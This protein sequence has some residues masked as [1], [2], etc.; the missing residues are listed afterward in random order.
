MAA[1]LAIFV[2]TVAWWA[3]ALWPT[4][5]ATPEW[6]ERTRAACFGSPPGGLPDTRGWLLLIGE[7]LGMVALL[8]VVW[9]GALSADIRRWHRSLAGR[10]VLYTL[11]VLVLGLLTLAVRQ[12]AA[13]QR[14]GSPPAVEPDGVLQQFSAN[15]DGLVLVDQHGEQQSLAALAERPALL[16][17]AFAHCESICPTLVADLLRARD[18]SGRPELP[19]IVITVDP[20]RDTPNRLPGIANGWQLG[21]HD[22]VLSGTIDEVEQALDRWQVSRTRNLSSGDVAHVPVVFLLG[23]GNITARLDGGWGGVASLL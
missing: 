23:D 18:Q 4:T 3:L 22:L 2:V 8:M 1:V 9:P 6:L 10:A 12:V 13:V 15:L 11:P 16:T 14:A 5:A 19:I 17:A 20:W 21:P 7:P